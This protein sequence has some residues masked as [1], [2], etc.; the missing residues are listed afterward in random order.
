MLHKWTPN[1]SGAFKGYSLGQQKGEQ[2]FLKNSEEY[3]KP[4]NKKDKQRKQQIGV[5]QRH[6]WVKQESYSLQSFKEKYFF[7]MFSMDRQHE[8]FPARSGLVFDC[9]ER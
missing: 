9:A 4:K 6:Q 2:I 3:E 1:F 7:F 8:I 5:Q